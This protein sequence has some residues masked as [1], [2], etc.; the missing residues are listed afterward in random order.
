MSAQPRWDH[1]ESAPRPV[2]VPAS[3][4]QSERDRNA[5]RIVSVIALASIATGA[6][7]VAAAATLGRDNGQNLAFFGVVAAA[8][9]VWGAI[10]LFWAPRWWLALG[11]LGNAVVVATWVVSRTVALPFGP[12]AHV[13]LPAGFA[14]ALATI[15]GTV[16]ALGAA[17]LAVRGSGPA[18]SAARVRSFALAAAVL[19]GALGLTGVV[20]Q[21]N[22]SSSGGNGGNGGGQYGPTA[23][24]GG[25]APVGGGYGY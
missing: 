25:G 22:A 20:S 18:R 8:E 11:A 12:Y 2:D 13:V 24:S 15:L 21:A 17:A 7:H 6:I 16:T 23:P 5:A 19:I 9:I 4:V 10:A 14:D 1:T 3:G